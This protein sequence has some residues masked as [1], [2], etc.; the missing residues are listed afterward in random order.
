[1]ARMHSSGGGKSG[2]KNPVNKKVPRWTDY[3]EDEVVDL[4]VRL[5]EDG[6]KPAQIGSKLRDQYGIPDVKTVTGSKLTEILE[7]EDMAL[8]MP[9]DL[10]NLLEK[11]E[12]IKDHYHDN[13]NDQ[14][15]ERQLRLVEAKI[16]RIAKYHRENGNIPENWKYVRD[17]K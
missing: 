10:Q 9:E 14:K 3:N 11:A 17:E 16:R 15:A 5:R 4:I 7:E 8:E 13:Q 6:L 12:S 2:S 1:M